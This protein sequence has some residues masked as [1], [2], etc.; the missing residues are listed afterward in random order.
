MITDAE[1]VNIPENVAFSLAL[2]NK[3][4]QIWHLT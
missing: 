3:M 1:R 4:D 2:Q